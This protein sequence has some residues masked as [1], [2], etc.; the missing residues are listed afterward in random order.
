MTY[1][2]KNFSLEELVCPH[3]FK[4]HGQRAWAFFDERILETLQTIRELIG[5][6]ITVNNWSRGGQ[7]SQRG[8][9]CTACQIIKEKSA[10]NKSYVSAHILFRAFDFDVE[11]MTAQQVRDFIVTN[12]D[13]LPHPIRLEGGVN[14]VHIDTYDFDQN[15]KI[16]IFTV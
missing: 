15:K 11:G 4:T 3:V 14:W 12:Q 10:A 2:P 9:R 16:E 5:K 7:F 1:K 6:P 8:C 13:K